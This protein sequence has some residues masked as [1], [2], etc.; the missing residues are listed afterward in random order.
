MKELNIFLK[1]I[2]YTHLKQIFIIIKIKSIVWKSKYAELFHFI[3]YPKRRHEMPNYTMEFQAFF[4][5][6]IYA[7]CLCF[8]LLLFQL[9]CIEINDKSQYI[10]Y[11]SIFSYSCQ[12]C[13]KQSMSII[14]NNLTPFYYII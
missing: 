6:H 5:M 3:Y 2:R 9:K 12:E 4:I 13:T 11:I 8:F 10:F 1:A 7:V 14:S